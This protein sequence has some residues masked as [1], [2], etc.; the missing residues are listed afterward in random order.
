[1][2]KIDTQYDDLKWFKFMQTLIFFLKNP[3]LFGK[4]VLYSKHKVLVC[5]LFVEIRELHTIPGQL[6]RR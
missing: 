3:P 1:M 6:Y 5:F 2:T 4:S